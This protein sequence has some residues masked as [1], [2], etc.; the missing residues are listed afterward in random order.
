MSGVVQKRRRSKYFYEARRLFFRVG[1]LSL[2]GKVKVGYK[3]NGKPKFD[4]YYDQSPLVGMKSQFLWWCDE[5]NLG[6][7][8]VLQKNEEFCFIS[9]VTRFMPLYKRRLWMRFGFLD[10]VRF[11]HHL[12]L[13]VNA[14]AFMRL[15]DAYGF[16][17]RMFARL[18]ANLFKKYG[19]FDFLRI[20]EPH[21]SGF[22]HLHVLVA[23][24]P[25]IDFNWLQSVW[26]KKYEGAGFV[27]RVSVRSSFNAVKYL[28]KYVN[29]MNVSSGGEG[30][31][32][33]TCKAGDTTGAGLKDEGSSQEFSAPLS[34]SFSAIL[35]ASNR[36]LFSMSRHLLG[37]A[38]LKPKV[39]ERSGFKYL[40]SCT[41]VEFDV[42]CDV[43]GF[44]KG[45]HFY[46]YESDDIFG[47]LYEFPDVFMCDR[48]NEE[49]RRGIGG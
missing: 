21:Q 8:A 44:E 40:G 17:N 38:G 45:K 11:E 3:D 31:F 15:V 18:R 29:K 46:R 27:K 26:W 25:F 14:N 9:Q 5:Y 22:P 19:K 49:D 35:F 6:K 20:L 23:G 24:I 39:R 42:F 12:V 28:L 7:Y 4:M 43:K 37:L 32:S 16:I 41:K 13:E 2:L 36:R 47:D 33:P 30:G 34:L 10:K 1:R 48:P